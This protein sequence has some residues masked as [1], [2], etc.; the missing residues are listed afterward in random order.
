MCRACFSVML[1]ELWYAG[2]ALAVKGLI[3]QHGTEHAQRA[4]HFCRVDMYIPCMCSS[5]GNDTVC[6]RVQAQANTACMRLCEL[7]G[8]NA[9]LFWPQKAWCGWHATC[10]CDSFH[11]RVHTYAFLVSFR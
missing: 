8:V 6:L 3:P 4:S 9:L 1:C 10:L 2:L 7:N 5:V 11:I